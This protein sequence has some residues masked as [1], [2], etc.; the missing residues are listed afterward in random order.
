[1]GTVHVAKSTTNQCL[2]LHLI[3]MSN[4]SANKQSAEQALQ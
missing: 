2:H 4:S 1:M 3:I